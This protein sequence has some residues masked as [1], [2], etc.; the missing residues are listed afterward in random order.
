MIHW[1]AVASVRRGEVG[2]DISFHV[3]PGGGVIDVQQVEHKFGDG[4]GGGE[5]RCRNVRRVEGGHYVEAVAMFRAELVRYATEFEPMAEE[6]MDHVHAAALAMLKD[7]NRHAGWR[8]PRHEAFEVC[9]P[10]I[11]WDVI[12]SVGAEDEIALGGGPGGHDRL[13][14]GIDGWHKLL[15]LVQQ[16]GVRFD[17]DCAVEGASEGAGDFAVAGP[18]INKHVP[19]GKIVHDLLQPAL[20]VPLL[21]GVIQENLKRLLVGLAL[22][23]KDAN[24]FRSRHRG[25]P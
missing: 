1:N 25:A 24:A 12:E 10:L 21:V 6:M 4:V 2:L 17:R 9:E 5:V 8:H 11:G 22:G 14:Y 20:S 3:L 13:A 16:I 18:G 7:D 23:I 19:R 15:E